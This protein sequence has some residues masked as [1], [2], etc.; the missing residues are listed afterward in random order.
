[1]AKIRILIVDDSVVMRRMITHAL[2]QDPDLEVVGTA[3][4]GRVAL[5]KIPQVNPDVITMDLNM[6]EMDGIMTLRE[7][8]KTHPKLGVIMFSTLTAA[9]AAMTVDALAAGASDY[10]TKPANVSSL[11]EG[12]ARLERE[13][14]PKIKM[15]GP[16]CP[17]DGRSPPVS[18]ATKPG[19]DPRPGSTAAKPTGNL[20]IVCIGAS[21]GGPNALAAVFEDFP[22]G[23]PVPIVIVQHM[24]PVFT[25]L[26]AER[27]SAHSRVT[28][29]EGSE[30]EL[31][32]PGR[33][34]IAPGGMH[35][36]VTRQGFLNRIHLHDRPAENSCRPAVDVL[37]R[38]IAAIYGPGALGVILTGMGK[39]GL[40]GCELMHE[41]QAQVVAQ[42]EASSVVWGMPGSVAR[43]GLA[44]AILP[45]PEIRK[46]ILRRVQQGRLKPAA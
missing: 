3:P 4:N 15:L 7:L 13:L 28:F 12:L 39:D 2:S 37:F 32:Q 46:E 45:L 25:G 31:L 19:T 14:I 42:D 22:A 17:S 16:Q 40:R 1:M 20:E 21:T 11:T 29:S 18:G 9:G 30:G 41:R 27:L 26:L 5:Q 24:P 35:M 34:Y 6:P 8:R 10:V 43:A 23:F 36:E 38:S 33:A 44:D